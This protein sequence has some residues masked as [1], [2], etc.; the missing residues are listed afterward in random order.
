LEL[1]P[2]IVARIAERFPLD[3]RALA[4]RLVGEARLHDGTVPAP[5]L[6]RC[7]VEAASGSVEKLRYYADLLKVDYRDVIVAGEYES[8]D[9]K[10]VRVRDLEQPFAV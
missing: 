6:Q 5:R 10:L 9:G 4:E 3:L 2:D 7:V 1:L 8:T